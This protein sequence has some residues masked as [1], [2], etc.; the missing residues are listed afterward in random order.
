MIVPERGFNLVCLRDGKDYR[1]DADKRLDVKEVSLDQ[2]DRIANEY[3]QKRAVGQE[4]KDLLLR[5][6][7]SMYHSVP[8]AGRRSKVLK[9]SA[10]G[11]GIPVIKAKHGSIEVRLDVAILRRKEFAVAFKFVK[12]TNGQGAMVPLTK[13]NTTD[14]QTWINKLNWIFGAQT[15]IYFKLIGADWVHIG[16]TLGQPMNADVFKNTLVQYKNGSVDLTCF[17]VGKYKGDEK[18][19]HAAGSYFGTEKVCVVDDGPHREFFDDWTYDSF[20]GLMAHEFAHFLGGPHHSRGPLL[21]S[22]EIETCELDKQLVAQLN[23]W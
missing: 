9:V 14:A 2:V 7:T 12:H 11:A 18:G 21:M 10:E 16:R 17:L 22:K 8:F 13:F 6:R 19:V 1:I 4:S 20:V 15:N 23:P 5:L 3:L